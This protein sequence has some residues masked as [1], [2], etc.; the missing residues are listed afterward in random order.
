[1]T[2]TRQFWIFSYTI[3]EYEELFITSEFNRLPPH[4]DEFPEIQTKYSSNVSPGSLTPVEQSVK[5]TPLKLIILL[6]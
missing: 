3:K 6:L 2:L 4:Y 5:I 1:M